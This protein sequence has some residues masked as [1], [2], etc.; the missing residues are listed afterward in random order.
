MSFAIAFA[1]APTTDLQIGRRPRKELPLMLPRIL[2]LYV[3]SGP[4]H[5]EN[6]ERIPDALDLMGSKN[7]QVGRSL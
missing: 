4:Q 1:F 7:I 6:S 3:H 2:I 5:R